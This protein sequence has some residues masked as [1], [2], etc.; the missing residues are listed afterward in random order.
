[1]Q[2]EG[3]LRAR[4]SHVV[5]ALELYDLSIRLNGRAAHTF[6]LRGCLWEQRNDLKR[7]I[8]DW[9]RCLAVQREHRAALAKLGSYQRQ[10]RPH[11]LEPR[12]WG[13]VSLLGAV[14][15]VGLLMIAMWS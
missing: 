13:Y 14:I 1:L 8:A 11:A 3:E 4:L 9:E 10:W 12:G 15:L 5:R 7:A 2:E 6:Y